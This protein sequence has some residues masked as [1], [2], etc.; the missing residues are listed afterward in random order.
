M[1]ANVILYTTKSILN[2]L[3]ITLCNVNDIINITKFNPINE[4]YTAVTLLRNQ[5]VISVIL[6]FNLLYNLN[7][8]TIKYI[9]IKIVTLFLNKIN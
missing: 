5:A 8:F 1:G 3:L 7:I 6:F 9:S 2:S 4:V